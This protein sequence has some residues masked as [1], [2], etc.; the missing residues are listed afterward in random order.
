MT[1]PLYFLAGARLTAGHLTECIADVARRLVAGGGLALRVGP[2]QRLSTSPWTLWPVEVEGDAQRALMA[3]ISEVTCVLARQARHQV[4]GL[5]LDDAH[6]TARLCRCEPGGEPETVA[7]PRERVAAT[8]SRWLSLDPARV[9]VALGMVDEAE[10]TGERD[11]ELLEEER[12]IE[13]KLAEAR[14]W[15]ERYRGGKG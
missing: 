6:D 8:L 9:A 5:A 14:E 1:A 15:M 3:S 11:P 13:R 7:G 4:V 2:E 12:F 10:P